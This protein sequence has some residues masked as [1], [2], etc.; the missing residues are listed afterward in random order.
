MKVELSLY[1][2]N[3]PGNDGCCSCLA[4]TFDPYAKVTMVGSE[5]HAKAEVLGQTE[6]LENDQ[7]PTWITPFDFDY[8]FGKP[9]RLMVAIYDNNGDPETSVAVT[10]FEV[11]KIMGRKGNVYAKKLR[12]GGR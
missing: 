7:S 9:T 6:V 3:L 2:R 5:A 11:G 8:E 1:A 4:G 12:D 10:T